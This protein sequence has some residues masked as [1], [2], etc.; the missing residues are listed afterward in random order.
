MGDGV[1][2]GSS[3]VSIILLFVKYGKCIRI[4]YF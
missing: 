3:M 1:G 2:K 4:S